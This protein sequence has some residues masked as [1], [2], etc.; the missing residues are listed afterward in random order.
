MAL[1]SSVLCSALN[2]DR[3]SEN[4]HNAQE[5][6]EICLFILVSY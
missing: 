2:S 4:A 1:K 6:L 5:L 3:F